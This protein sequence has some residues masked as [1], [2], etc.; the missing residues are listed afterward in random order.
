MEMTDMLELLV[1]NFK[2]ILKI[3]NYKYAWNK[4]EIESLSREIKIYKDPNGDFRAEVCIYQIKTS[5]GRLDS[6]MEENRKRISEPDDGKVEIT[7][8]EQQTENELKNKETEYEQS[9]RGMSDY[10]KVFPL[11]LVESCKEWRK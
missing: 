7:K 6:R 4:W 8:C 2:D 1:K 10:D 5:V 11:M 9:L 3:S